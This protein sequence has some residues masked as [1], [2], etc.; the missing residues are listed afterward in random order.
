M[1]GD[2]TWG[3]EHPIQYRGGIIQLYRLNRCHPNK[4]NKHLKKP[5]RAKMVI[6]LCVLVIEHNHSR[7]LE[8]QLSIIMAPAA[9]VLC[10]R[11]AW[12][13]LR[14]SFYNIT[15]SENEKKLMIA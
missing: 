7:D 15:Y 2:L 3:G 6:N 5:K 13:N 1:E 14:G 9:S 10:L 4:F 11:F 12:A 8:G